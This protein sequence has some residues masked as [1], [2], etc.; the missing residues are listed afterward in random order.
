MMQWSTRR[1]SR[2]RRWRWRRAMPRARASTATSRHSSS[3]SSSSYITTVEHVH[4]S[5]LLVNWRWGGD[6][7]GT[8]QNSG[9]TPLPR[10]SPPRPS[11]GPTL[12]KPVDPGIGILGRRKGRGSRYSETRKPGRIS[13]LLPRAR[14]PSHSH[15]PRCHRPRGR[16]RSAE[17]DAE[18]TQERP[19]SVALRPRCPCVEGG[20]HQ[21]ARDCKPAPDPSS[22][23]HPPAKRALLRQFHL[24][25]CSSTRD[26]RYSGWSG[27]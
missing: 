25:T 16:Q 2:A 22:A 5:S 3:S 20:F 27:G 7:A 21:R 9:I 8:L 14:P 19:A 17:T 4:A 26:R 24:G 12:V 18:H 11:P 1:T 10:P 23:H 6:G 15:S 13:H